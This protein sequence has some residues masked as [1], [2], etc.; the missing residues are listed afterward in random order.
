MQNIVRLTTV[1]AL[2]CSSTVFGA[3]LVTELYTA[4]VESNC[5]EG[6]VTCDNVLIHIYNNSDGSLKISGIGHTIH[7]MSKDGVPG[8][9]Q[10]YEL[11]DGAATIQLFED[12]TF[13]VTLDKDKV[14]QDEQ[15]SWNY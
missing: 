10:G 12:G 8:K 4:K 15:G 6:N 3:E 9:F 1:I 7:N 11:I 2:A 13:R 5:E 14:V